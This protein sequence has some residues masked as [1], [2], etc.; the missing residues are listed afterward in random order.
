MVGIIIIFI[1]VAILI[2]GT[3]V[4]IIDN[5][6]E[7]AAILC[8]IAIIISFIMV[9]NIQKCPKCGHIAVG[10]SY[11]AE[12]GCDLAGCEL[13]GGTYPCPKCH[14]EVGKNQKFCTKCGTNLQE[15]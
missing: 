5:E 14:E 6:P 10:Q 13:I 2:V 8:I 15:E 12:C 3:V 7:I 11:C 1:I 9:A 4:E